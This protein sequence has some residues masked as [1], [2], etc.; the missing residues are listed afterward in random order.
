MGKLEDDIRSR[1]EDYYGSVRKFA[2]EIGVPEQTIYSLLKKDLCGGSVNNVLP[3]IAKL[4]LDPN[5][6]LKSRIVEVNPDGQDPDPDYIDVPLYGSIAAGEPLE[7][8]VVDDY[9]PVPRVLVERHP[10]AYLLRVRGTSMDRKLPDGSLALIDPD[11]KDVRSGKTYALNVN[12]YAS[13]VKQVEPLANGVKL[14]PNSSDPTIQPKV[15]DFN[16]ADTESITILGRVIW[17][18]FPFDYEI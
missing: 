13:T 16:D 7:M 18:T 5:W 2:Q 9:F 15:Y 6:I 4:G 1:I 12:G 14:V 11:D 8:N 3:I 17:A 10:R